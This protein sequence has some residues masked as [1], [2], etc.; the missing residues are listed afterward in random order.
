MRREVGDG[1]ELC[2]ADWRDVDLPAVDAV[3]EDPPYGRRTHEG[4]AVVDRGKRWAR[5]GRSTPDHRHVSSLAVDGELGYD[6]LDPDDVDK[7]VQSAHAVCDGWILDMTSHDL[8]PAYEAALRACDRYVF[9]PIPIVT[10][11]MNVR[12][13]GDGPSN[14]TVYL[15]VSRTTRKK[16]WGT[17]PGGYPGHSDNDRRTSKVKGCKALGLMQAIV[18]DY[19]DRGDLVLDRFAGGGTTGV[20]SIKLGRRFFGC[21]RKPEHFEIAVRRLRAAREQR[22]LFDEPPPK[23]AKAKQAK[24]EGVE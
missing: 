3:I 23:R 16:C 15:I 10:P 18:D 2:C 8:I 5:E 20:A 13:S 12:L 19:T 7:I 22:G 24:I 6:H 21:E 11:G 17:K 1:W 4:Q 14:W 9:A